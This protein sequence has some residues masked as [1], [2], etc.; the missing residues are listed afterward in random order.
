MKH[1]FII[2]LVCM[3]LV[4]CH[5]K[6]EENKYNYVWYEKVEE[7]D[8]NHLDVILLKPA[9]SN[10]KHF[11]KSDMEF[12]KIKEEELPEI[13]AYIFKEFKRNYYL[14]PLSHYCRQ[15]I[16]YKKKGELYV[17]VNFFSYI[18]RIGPNI[19]TDYNHTIITGEYK[20]YAFGHILINLSKHKIVEF[21]FA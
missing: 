18:K 1:I 21:K 11:I 7:W 16:G 13:K 20:N 10:E 5:N 6:Q 8:T 14:L 9:W 15:Y 4:S 2:I 17:Y 3:F 19:C 12:Y